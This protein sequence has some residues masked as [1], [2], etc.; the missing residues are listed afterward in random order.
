MGGG[1]GLVFIQIVVSMAA[2][3]L[4]LSALASGNGDKQA[5][6]SGAQEVCAVAAPLAPANPMQ[7]HDDET[8]HWVSLGLQK[9]GYTAKS[10]KEWAAEV[11]SGYTVE[12]GLQHCLRN[13][14]GRRA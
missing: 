14:G 13:R 10:A 7:S 9:F 4:L 1:N 12:Q 5:L 3:L 11:P 2:G 8:R 6:N